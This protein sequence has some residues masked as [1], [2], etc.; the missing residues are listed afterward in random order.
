MPKP[1]GLLIIMCS[2]LILIAGCF[3][4]NETESPKDNDLDLVED[5]DDPDDDNDGMLDE[6][7]LLY[8][9]DPKNSADKHLDFDGDGIDNKNEFDS[10]SNPTDIMDYSIQLKGWISKNISQIYE[11]ITSITNITQFDDEDFDDDGM[12]NLW[13]YENMLDMFDPVDAMDDPDDDRYVNKAEYDQATDPWS[14][15]RE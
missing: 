14:G 10:N 8:G 3:E 1:W 2:I 4:G 9:F 15:G 11:N 12:S 7:E 5:H 6:W 13:E